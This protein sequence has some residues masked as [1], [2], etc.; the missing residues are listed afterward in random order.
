M[1][2]VAGSTSYL[3]REPEGTST[4]TITSATS[5][6]QPRDAVDEKVE[7]RRRSAVDAD[8]GVCSA[9]GAAPEV[10]DRPAAAELG[11]ALDL[12]VAQLRLDEPRTE[13]VRDGDGIVDP[14]DVPAV[15]LAVVHGEEVH[16]LR[17]E[18]ADR[19]GVTE[20]VLY[21]WAGDGLL[22]HVEPDHRHVERRVEDRL[23]GLGVGP[24]VELGGRGHVPLRD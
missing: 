5:L 23:C 9:V 17:D 21:V 4:K 13:D 19:A 24:D 14:R 8:V 7:E 15:R 20:P 18:D 12:D 10:D 2:P 1:C 11:V 6:P 16:E 22:R 3:F